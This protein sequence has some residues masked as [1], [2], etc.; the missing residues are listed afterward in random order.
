M[1]SSVAFRGGRST[2]GGSK[3]RYAGKQ[4]GA[5]YLD[6]LMRGRW[7]RLTPVYEL[8]SLHISRARASDTGRTTEYP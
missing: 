7:S 3:R 4:G 8:N 5:I 6:Q 2:R 1:R